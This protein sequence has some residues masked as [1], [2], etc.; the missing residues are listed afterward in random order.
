MCTFFLSSLFVTHDFYRAYITGFPT[1]CGWGGATRDDA[2]FPAAQGKV[3]I[4]LSFRRFGRPSPHV[5]N[6]I[7]ACPQQTGGGIKPGHLGRR[8][9]C[10]RYGKS[11]SATADRQRYNVDPVGKVQ[12]G[13]ALTAT[14]VL[15]A[16][17]AFNDAYTVLPRQ[18][19]VAITLTPWGQCR[20]GLLLH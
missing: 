16:R 9:K 7:T 15:R 19:S 14:Q 6:E 5:H 12:T 8:Q 18:T 11:C 13:V 20:P 1:S 4:F 17:P 3:V 10:S 2:T